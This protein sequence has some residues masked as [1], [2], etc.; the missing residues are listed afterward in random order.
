MIDMTRRNNLGFNLYQILTKYT[1]AGS[2][3]R[4]ITDII[5]RINQD[6]GGQGPVS[7]FSQLTKEK[8]QLPSALRQPI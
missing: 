2:F 1:A 6:N 3:L 4:G 7:A 8:D 5:K